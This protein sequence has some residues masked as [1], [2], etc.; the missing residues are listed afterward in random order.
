MRIVCASIETKLGDCHHNTLAIQE[1]IVNADN[2]EADIVVFPELTITGCTCGDIFYNSSLVQQ[3]MRS[4]LEINTFSKESSSVIVIGLP[5]AFRD[6]LFDCAAVIFKGKIYGIVPKNEISGAGEYDEDRWFTDAPKDCH[7]L[8]IDG[9]EVPFGRSI[10]FS[11][12]SGE[13]FAIELGADLRSPFCISSRLCQCGAN[14]ILH[15]AG[16]RETVSEIDDRRKL[17][18]AR[19]LMQSSVYVFCAGGEQESSTDCVYTGYKTVLARGKVEAETDCLKMRRNMLTADV[20]PCEAR[21][22]RMR[23]GFDKRSDKDDTTCTFVHI[24]IK[25]VNRYEFAAKNREPF[26]DQMDVDTVCARIVHLQTVALLKK[27]EYMDRKKLIIGVSGGL[28]SAVALLSCAE[29]Y[30]SAGIDV[31]NII[32][33]TM[34]GPGTSNRTHQNALQLMASLGITSVT[35]NITD[36]VSRHL[37]NIQH[38]ENV[39]DITYE[40]TQSRERTKV[41]LDYANK[42]NGIVIGTGDMSE[43]ALGWMTYSGDHISMYAL[44]CGI[45]KTVIKHMAHWYCRKADAMLRV[46]LED[47]LDTPVSPELLPLDEHGEQKQSTESLVGPYI[48]HDF[49]LYHILTNAYSMQKLFTLA[50]VTFPEYSDSDIKKWLRIFIDRFFTRQ[51]KRSCFSDGVQ[52][53]DC[54]LSPRGYWRMPSDVSPSLWL[55]EVDQL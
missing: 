50:C 16:S 9:Y 11:S 19:S 5:I 41:L 38:S 51:Y 29:A 33:I 30:R 18:E 2:Q 7:A 26:I 52:V 55:N 25:T 43:F 49:F 47:I 44:N 32:G 39:F 46:V 6:G 28:D 35:V 34:P 3:S 23:S 37:K 54:G 14:L 17:L 20:F 12:D 31:K 8:S 24:P 45:P 48:I 22:V 36:A 42:E 21:P 27:A 4:L 53:F 40:Q 1:Q 13:I 10:L 15:L